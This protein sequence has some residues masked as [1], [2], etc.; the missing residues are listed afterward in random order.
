[1]KSRLLISTRRFSASAEAAR[2]KL[3]K[4]ET[5]APGQAPLTHQSFAGRKRFYK[6]VGVKRIDENKVLLI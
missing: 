6:Q 1:M 3:K 5:L 4:L 2:E